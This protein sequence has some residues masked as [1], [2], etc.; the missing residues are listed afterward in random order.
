MERAPNGSTH[1]PLLLQTAPG[2]SPGVG[3]DGSAHLYIVIVVSFYGVFL[4]GILIGYARSKRREKR[5]VNVFTR[6]LHE[7]EQRGWGAGFPRKH[8]GSS[9][10]FPAFPALRDA[11]VARLACA[12][13]SVEQSSV[14]S[15]CSSS[16]ARLAIEEEEADG[17]ANA[18]AHAQAREG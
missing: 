16:D 11:H 15:L 12:L 7:E 9:L 10:T 18:H 2:A 4:V 13:C 14:S 5:R 6:L 3:S 1:E 17:A 8:S